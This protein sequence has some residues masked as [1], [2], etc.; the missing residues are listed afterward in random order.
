MAVDT[1]Q[2][3]CSAM[4]LASPWRSLLPFPNTITQPDRQQVP[5][6]YSGILAGAPIIPTLTEGGTSQPWVWH[7]FR[8]R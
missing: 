4:H 1:A 3:R 7:L 2:K 8:K 6:M 5:F